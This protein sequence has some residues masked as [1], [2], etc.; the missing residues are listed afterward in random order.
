MSRSVFP[1]DFDVLGIA[2]LSHNDVLASDASYHK[3]GCGGVLCG[4]IMSRSPAREHPDV[5]C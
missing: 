5:G 3:L 2:R 1:S 4:K